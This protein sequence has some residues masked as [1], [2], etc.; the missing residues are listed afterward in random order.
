M[1]DLLIHLFIKNYENTKEARVRAAYGNLAGW[2]GI[3]CNILLCAFK[4]T[5][6]LLSGSLSIAADG[7]NN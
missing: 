7:V 3:I 5:I 2:V 4:M 1:T 6:G